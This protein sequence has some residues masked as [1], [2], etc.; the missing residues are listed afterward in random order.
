M[1]KNRKPPFSLS[2]LTLAMVATAFMSSGASAQ[3]A[4]V[5]EEILVT[6]QF[7]EQSLQSTPLSVTA[8]SGD[9][10]D[11]RGQTRLADITAQAPNVMLQVNPAGGGNSMRAFIRGVGQGDQSP[12]VDPGV[13]IYID[14][15]YFSTVTGSVFDLMDLDRVEILRGPQGTLAG[16]NSMGGAVRMFSRKPQG[17]GGYVEA[18]MGSFNRTDVKAAGDFTLLDNILYA[19]VSGV[20]RHRDGY[21]T[22][23]DYACVHPDDPEVISGAIPRTSF[24]PS[25]KIG[26]LGGQEMSAVKASLR[27]LASDDVEV[28]IHADRTHDTSETQPSVL[29]GAGEIIPGYS[30]QYQGVSYDNRYVPF[31]PNRGDSVINDPYVSYANFTNPGV[32]YT[33][34]DTAG[35][36]GPAN[37]AWYTAPANELTGYGV[38]GTVD[39]QLGDNMALKSITAYREYQTLSGQDNDGSPVV[40][41]QSLSD[42]SHEQFSQEFRLSGVAFNRLL[43]YTAGAIYFDQETV[44]ASRE[45]SVFVPFGPDLS[46]PVFDF[47]QNDTTENSYWAVF[48]HGI[49]NLTDRL[50]LATGVRYTDQDK[51]YTFNRLNVDGRTAFLPLS[52]PENPL[53]GTV[54]SFSGDNID[55]RLNLSWQATS[56]LMLYFEHATGFKGGGIS[57]RPYFPEQVRGFDVET[58]D[59]YEFGWK[60]RFLNGAL[61]ANGAVFYNDYK[62]YQQMPVQCVDAAGKVLPAPFDEPCGQYANVADAEVRGA[63]LELRYFATDNLSIDAAWS[64]LDFEFQEPFIETTSVIDGAGAPGIGKRKWSLGAQYSHYL[65]SGAV[66]SPRLDLN[67]MPEYCTNMNCTTVNDDYTLTNLRVSYIS[68][69][70]DWAVALEANNLTDELYV[71]NQLNTVY[72]SHQVGAPRQWA[73][74]VRRNW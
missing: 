59:A 24:T 33:P 73:V 48:A 18:S 15:V 74:S 37:G 31:G 62:D 54:G 12:A 14:D 23:L 28:N 34:I 2:P 46:K 68:P 40:I 42:F 26:T 72:Q 63:E 9:M 20:S 64:W 35:N 49:W 69:S 19:R 13:G 51:D 41:L 11:A 47:L 39:W 1:K 67:Y 43:D 36:P 38:S 44:Y 60:G 8:I 55:Y 22:R 3:Q 27:W 56:D 25:C 4:G 10:L 21:I 17:E 29:R 50:T 7:R 45:L 5:I 52:N 30:Q 16:M 32:S 53:N 71:L 61:Q 66:I 70:E 6:A 65:A 57:P 58:L